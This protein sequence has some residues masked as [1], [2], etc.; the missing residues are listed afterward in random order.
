MIEIEGGR[1]EK[2]SILTGD[3]GI[4]SGI[5]AVVAY[6]RGLGLHRRYRLV[7]LEIKPIISVKIDKVNPRFRMR[8]CVIGYKSFYLKMSMS[9]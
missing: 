8:L 9:I 1:L 4:A 6:A 3:S 2:D 7:F 5:V